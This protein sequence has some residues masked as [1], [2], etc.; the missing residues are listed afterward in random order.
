MMNQADLQTRLGLCSWSVQPTSVADLVTKMNQAGINCVQLN[1]MPLL[2]D[3]DDW[4][5]TTA[6]LTDAGIRI[7]SGMFGTVGEDYSSIDSIRQTGGVVPDG[8]WSANWKNIQQI[9]SI[10]Q[11]LEIELTTFHAGFIPH[12]S[13]DP[14]Y[15]KIADRIG[16]I[17]NLFATNGMNVGLETGQERAETLH[18]FLNDLN[19]PNVGVNF[20][21]GNMILYSSGD[22]VEALRLLGPRLMQCHIKDAKRTTVPGTWGTEEAVGSG[23]VDWNAFLA[24]LDAIDFRGNLVIEREAGPQRLNDIIQAKNVI[25]S[26]G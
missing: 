18:R 15:G 3:L 24:E 20:D 26:G 6:T 9:A 16:Q 10:A 14:V 25:S 19:Q 21:P 8:T 23:D 12:D 13:K 1:L 7:I 5:N 11:S 4:Q 17:A 2:K 22:P